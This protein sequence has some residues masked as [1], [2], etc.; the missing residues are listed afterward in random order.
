MGL[1]LRSPDWSSKNC[2]TKQVGLLYLGTCPVYLAINSFLSGINH[3]LGIGLCPAAN[4]AFFSSPSTVVAT[5]N[6]L[7]CSVRLCGIQQGLSRI[8]CSST[9]SCQLNLPQAHPEQEKERNLFAVLTIID[10]GEI[11]LIA[12]FGKAATKLHRQV[13]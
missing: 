7:N 4:N 2:S 6:L 3:W 12:S 10:C 8:E 9:L 5:L 13:V 11:G 1:S